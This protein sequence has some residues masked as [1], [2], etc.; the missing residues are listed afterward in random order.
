[1]V[2][3]K[4]YQTKL[5]IFRVLSMFKKVSKRLDSS[6]TAPGLHKLWNPAIT[7]WRTWKDEKHLPDNSKHFFCDSK[8]VIYDL[9]HSFCQPDHAIKN[10]KR[11]VEA[12]NASIPSLVE[13]R[14]GTVSSVSYQVFISFRMD[15]ERLREYVLIL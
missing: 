5:T 12:C 14:I 1:M 10:V 7:D 11:L 3:I 8:Y 2:K 9:K 4:L 6:H 15:E 13:Y